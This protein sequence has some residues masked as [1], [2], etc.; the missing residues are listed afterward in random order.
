MSLSSVILNNSEYS[1]GKLHPSIL[2]SVVLDI[3]PDRIGEVMAVAKA[4]GVNITS[5]KFVA[6]TVN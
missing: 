1:T 2:R 4:H 3:D 6:R 5:V